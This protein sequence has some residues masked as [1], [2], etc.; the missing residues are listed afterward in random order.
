MSVT[1]MPVERRETPTSTSAVAGAWVVYGTELLKLTGQLRTRLALVLCV[2]AP[3][4]FVIVLGMQDSTPDDTLYGR[5]VHTS[6]FAVPLVILGFAS[7]WAFPALAC[8]VAGDMFAAEDH[9]GT[10]HAILTRSR[11]RGQIFAGKALAAMTYSV[12]A[13]A[14]LAVCSLLAGILVLGHQPLVNLSGIL[15]EPDQWV[16]LVLA[17]WAAV[18]PPV[19]GF[20]AI[21]LLMS[22]ATRSAPAGIAAPV[23]LG[24]LMQLYSLATGPDIV[25]N[26]LLAPAFN[27]WHGLLTSDPF[28]GPLERNLLISAVY[29]VVCLSVAYVLLRRRDMKGN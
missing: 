2:L 21:G 22:V 17:S 28:Y 10:W 4:A 6:G 12:A 9:F 11:S 16:R 5:W 1:D 18:L 14:V 15:V 26:L 13:V 7:Q 23:A 27:S 24:L 20:T 25:R 19:L 3:F 8:I 29:V